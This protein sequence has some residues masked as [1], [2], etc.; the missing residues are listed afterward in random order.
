VSINPDWIVIHIKVFASVAV[1]L[2]KPWTNFVM[3]PRLH[4]NLCIKSELFVPVMHWT[5]L[6]RI[7]SL[8]F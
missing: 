6:K 5:N 3:I 7:C 8:S 2:S 1:I 4:H